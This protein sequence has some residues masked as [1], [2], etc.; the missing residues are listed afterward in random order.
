MLENSLTWLRNY[1]KV[2][3][4]NLF[5]FIR[6]GY[7]KKNLTS[8]NIKKVLENIRIWISMYETVVILYEKEMI[9]KESDENSK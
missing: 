1:F 4:Q 6:I 3:N 9:W 2:I 7:E 5:I 8:I